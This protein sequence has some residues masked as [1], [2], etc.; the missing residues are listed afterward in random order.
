MIRLFHFSTSTLK[1]LLILSIIAGGLVIGMGHLLA[2]AISDYRSEIE[3][4]LS[5]S[6]GQTVNIGSLEGSWSGIGPELILRDL[7]LSDGGSSEPHLRLGEVHISIGIIDSLRQ[8]EP[9]IRKITLVAPRLRITRQESGSVTI[10]GLGGIADTGSDSSA[11]FLLPTRLG[12]QKGE[13]LWSDITTGAPP[14][15]LTEVTLDLHNDG[16]RHQLTGSLALT[17]KADS[18]LQLAIDLSGQ[19]NRAETWSAD[20]YFKG[21]RI[22]LNRLLN[23]RIPNE[24]RFGKGVAEVE[25]WSRWEQGK[26]VRLEGTAD[27]ESFTLMRKTETEQETRRQ[28]FD[29]LSGSFQWRRQDRGWRLDVADIKFQRMGLSWPTTRCSLRS[30][31]N[32]Q[33]Q[34]QLSAGSSFARLEDINAISSL[35]PNVPAE[36]GESLSG[37]Q[38]HGDL[39]DLRFRY[40][41]SDLGPLWSATAKARAIYTQPW[42]RIPGIDNLSLQ[43]WIDQEKGKVSLASEDVTVHLPG[44]F[45]DPLQLNQLQGDLTWQRMDDGGW[46]IATQKLTAENS[47]ISSISRLR[48]QFPANADESVFMDLQTDFRDG[49]ASTTPR[50]LPA[51]IMPD[52]VVDWVDRSIIKGRVIEGSAIVRGP[53]KD[54]PFAKT[55]SGRFEVFFTTEDLTLDYWPGWPRLEKLKARVRFLNTRFDTWVQRGKIFGSKLQS[56]HARIEDLT[57]T[58]PFKLTGDVTGDFSDVLRLLRE[59]PLKAEFAAMTKGIQGAGASILGLDF[60]I[61]INDGTPFQLDGKLTFQDT[62]LHLDEWQLTL[63]DIKGDLFF[64][65]EKIHGKQIKG[66]TLGNSLQVDVSTP[67]ENSK[68]T[69]ITAH[70]TIPSTLLMDRF[71]DLAILKKAH[72]SGNWQLQI[73]I[74]HLAA[75]PGAAVPVVVTSNLKGLTIDQPAPIGKSPLEEREFY[76][77]SDFSNKPQRSLQLRYGSLID[78]ALLLDVSDSAP[79]TLVRGGIRLGG[80]KARIPDKDGLIISGQLQKL[81]LDP[82][83]KLASQPNGDS[84]LPPINQLDLYFGQLQ[85]GEMELENFKLLLNREPD[86]WRGDISSNRFN[87]QLLIPENLQR[88]PIRA[89]LKKLDITLDPDNIS[90][91]S[92]DDAA[93]DFNPAQMPAIEATIDQVT[94]NSQPFGALQLISRKRPEGWE[95]QTLTLN[96]KKLQLSAAL[97]WSQATNAKQATNV[98][99]SLKS[100]N[101]GALLGDLGFTQNIDSAPAEINSRLNWQGSPLGFRKERLNGQVGIQIGEGR[102]LE[103]DPGIGRIF[104]LLNIGALQ[105]RLTL[106]FSDIFKKGFAFDSIEGDFLLDSGDAYTNNFIMAGPSA[107]IEIA[108]RTGLSSEDFDQLVTFTPRLSSSLTMAGA[109]AAGPAVGAALLLAQ[110]IIGNKLDK[111]TQIQYIVT[112]PWSDPIL[113]PK[114][115]ERPKSGGEAAD[116]DS[117]ISPAPKQDTIKTWQLPSP[118]GKRQFSLTDSKFNRWEEKPETDTK[119]SIDKPTEDQEQ[120]KGFFSRL[121]DAVKPTGKTYQEPNDKNTL[122]NN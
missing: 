108:G 58:S 96:S 27:W 2:P 15:L 61:P 87:G 103:V 95:I 18:R 107:T 3:Q 26:M 39:H 59:S 57:R 63:N 121:F 100:G 116:M 28:N 90:A 93:A 75:G 109:I 84:H 19:L 76:L 91:S 40:S 86:G 35:F 51:G 22:N 46:Q 106:D 7:A 47:D 56:A 118:H 21:S 117:L 111:V 65:Q 43:L 1:H 80:A 55:P 52:T 25:L 89:S 5:K 23:R 8:R 115:I 41:D 122:P 78:M 81:K 113:T 20:I 10:A 64:D 11:A 34:L 45:R 92:E 13:V 68:A 48:M 33:G 42:N 82:W 73:D 98:D 14:L 94:I 71:P 49:D 38:L 97:Q 31:R 9:R 32:K 99:L 74:P 6:L 54:F 24:Y 119:A 104:G 105:R 114:T 30:R 72:G 85:V 66:T 44:L 36:L 12:I 62:T 112:G 69:R 37:I 53:L 50:Y 16:D 102:F 17:E 83:L 60:S 77:A 101:L 4:W 29:H 79:P 67:P 110:Q 120:Q 70:S 88:T